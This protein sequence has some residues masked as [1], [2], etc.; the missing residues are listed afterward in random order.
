[1]RVPSQQRGV[2]LLIVLMIV[3]LVVIV[4]AD[5]GSRLQIQVQRTINIKDNNQAYWYALGAEAFARTSIATL[6]D[7]S[8]DKVVL[9]EEWAQEF[10]YPVDNGT[11]KAQLEDAQ[12]CFNLNALS[13]SD[14]DRSSQTQASE[15][16][17]AFAAMLEATGDDIDSYTAETVRDGLADWLDSDTSMRTYGAEDSEYESLEHPYLAANSLM[18]NQSELRLINGVSPTW[19]NDILPLICVIPDETTL[20]INVNT[21]TEERAPIL[22]GL[23]GLSLSQASNLISSRSEDGWSTIDDFLNEPTMAA[24]D[25]SDTQ[26]DWFTVTTKYF[27]LHI[28][29]SYNNATFS[30]TSLFSAEGGESVQVVRREFG[31]V[32]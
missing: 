4:A 9:S 18:T 17:E 24:L 12:S 1:M 3:A 19:L 31:G 20:A 14:N 28:K 15:E 11:I 16:M 25:L 32:K 7:E 10:M 13:P 2:A 27:I 26:R 5:M 22:A 30:L 21:L 23:T 8:D 29:T 6:L